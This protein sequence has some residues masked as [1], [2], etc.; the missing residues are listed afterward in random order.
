MS[1]PGRLLVETWLGLGAA[2][3]FF[4]LFYLLLMAVRS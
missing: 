3:V 4:T 1:R 2:A